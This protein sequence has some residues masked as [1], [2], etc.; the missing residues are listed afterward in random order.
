[1]ESASEGIEECRGCDDDAGA[2]L[3]GGKGQRSI[4]R[5]DTSP[6]KRLARLGT[7]IVQ[8]PPTGSPGGFF[9]TQLILVEKWNDTCRNR[10][11]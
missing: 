10:K 2:E 5:S 9:G 3:P 7:A 8:K 11:F 1:M 4:R 6:A